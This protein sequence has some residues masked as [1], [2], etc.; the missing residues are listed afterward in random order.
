MAEGSDEAL[1]EELCRL[2]WLKPADVPWDFE[3]LSYVRDR[4]PASGTIIDVGCG[5]GIVTSLALGGKLPATYDRYARVEA[6]YQHIGPGQANDLFANT[7][8]GTSLR[9]QRRQVDIGIDPKDY[10]LDA[11]RQTGTYRTVL[12]ETCESM[13]L[14]PRSVDLAM[15]IFALYWVDDLTLAVRNIAE[16]LVPGGSLVTVMPTEFNSA[17]HGASLLH[18]TYQAMGVEHGVRWFGEMEG[19][20]RRFINRHAGSAAHW[21]EFFGGFGLRVVDLRPAIHFQRFMIQDTFQRG[22]FPYFLECSRTA[23]TPEARAAFIDAFTKPVAR[24]ILRTTD[25]RKTTEPGAYYLI[26]LVKS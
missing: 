24:A 5:D 20:R 19:N 11:A 16:A 3:V 12:K 26:T 4:I 14:P 17:M 22:L 6:G 21:G 13:S 23:T 1:F 15:A 25:A 18:E 8:V 9:G 7:L 10:H 2:Y